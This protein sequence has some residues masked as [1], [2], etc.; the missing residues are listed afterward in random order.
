MT[1]HTDAKPTLTKYYINNNPQQN[2]DHEVHREGCPWMP[3]FK[4]RTCLGAFPT[5][6]QAVEA[7]K[8]WGDPF[9]DGCVHCSPECHTS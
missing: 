5:C 2:N 4:N 8:G 1:E 3:E 6:H 7:A 9:A